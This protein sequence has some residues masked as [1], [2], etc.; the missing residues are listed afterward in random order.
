MYATVCSDCSLHQA[1]AANLDLVRNQIGDA[2]RP[3]RCPCC[4]NQVA[5]S[6]SRLAV[7]AKLCCIVQYQQQTYTAAST[8]EEV[9]TCLRNGVVYLQCRLQ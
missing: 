8:S 7:T 4:N 2:I 6:V 5:Q 9:V 1:A 3:R